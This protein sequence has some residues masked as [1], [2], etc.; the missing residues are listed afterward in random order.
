M[1]RRAALGMTAVIMTA[2]IVAGA[3]AAWATFTKPVAASGSVSTNTISAPTALSATGTVAVALSWTA[4]TSAWATGT[5]VFRSTTSGS[6]YSQI[7]QIAGLSTTTYTDTPGVGTFYYVVE[8]YYTG[9]SANWTSANSNQAS[10]TTVAPIPAFVQNVGSASCGGT[11]NSVTVPA[12]GV[13]AGHTL[14]VSVAVE[15]TSSGGTVTAT[16]SAGNTYS[17]DVDIANGT[18]VRTVI[19]SAPVVTALSSGNTVT[20]TTPANN[21]TVVSVAEFS[22]IASASR[23]DTSGKTS[24]TGNTP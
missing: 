24:G 21:A 17:V 1:S 5:R 11:T 18:A 7:A 16:D 15:Q 8:A 23:L 6:G 3:G 20:V 12:S 22:G 2:V 10:A 13:P 14:V 4:T 19:L 9:N